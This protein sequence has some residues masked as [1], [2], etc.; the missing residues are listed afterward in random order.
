MDVFDGSRSFADG[1]EG[2]G[3]V[4]LAREADP[5]VVFE[6]LLEGA[7]IKV[8]LINVGYPII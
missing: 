1:N 7:L 6:L 8:L 3:F 4:T 2:V 5:T